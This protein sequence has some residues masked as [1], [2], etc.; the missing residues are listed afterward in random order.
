[1]MYPINNLSL[2]ISETLST[3]LAFIQMIT[4]LFGDP[5]YFDMDQKRFL[6]KSNCTDGITGEEASKTEIE[7]IDSL[8]MEFTRS[9]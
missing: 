9:S 5:L 8:Y 3:Y 2:G 6:A 7:R 1:M 4:I